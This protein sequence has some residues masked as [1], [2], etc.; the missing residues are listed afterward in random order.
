M[1]KKKGSSTCACGAG[2]CSCADDPHPSHYSYAATLPTAPPSAW[3]S[4]PLS[5]EC[6][7]I[8]WLPANV[9]AG[10]VPP[11]YSRLRQTLAK[12]PSRYHWNICCWTQENTHMAQKTRPSKPC[13]GGGQ[14]ELHPKTV[15]ELGTKEDKTGEEKIGWEI[16]LIQEYM[17]THWKIQ[18]TDPVTFPP[19][20][21]IQHIWRS[22][23]SYFDGWNIELFVH[24]RCVVS[25]EVF[26]LAA[27]TLDVWYKSARKRKY[28]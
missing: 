24:F 12:S 11:R 27:H 3:L 2:P 16:L 22:S 13:A 4:P 10:R 25:D 26:V 8:S 14:T 6:C 28:T 23:F 21:S 18:G 7:W 20:S 1:K 9:G 15:R 5:W 17:Q 19:R